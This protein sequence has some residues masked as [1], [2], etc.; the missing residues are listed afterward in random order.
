MFCSYGRLPAHSSR[1]EFGITDTERSVAV[2]IEAALRPFSRARVSLTLLSSDGTYTLHSVHQYDRL[3]HWTMSP[4][5]LLHF[6]IPQ[7]RRIRFA[8][9]PT[10]QRLRRCWLCR[11]AALTARYRLHV[12]LPP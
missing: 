2:A 1:R 3:S 6:K 11:A 8:S 9:R 5:L 4:T 7:V 10:Q 12:P